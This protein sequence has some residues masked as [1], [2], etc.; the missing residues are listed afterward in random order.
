MYWRIFAALLLSAGIVFLPVQGSGDDPPP[1]SP[2]QPT[3]QLRTATIG[4]AGGPMQ[5]S[6][7]RQEGTLAQPTP[8]GTATGSGYGLYSGIWK[9]WAG[10]ATGVEEEVPVLADQ[11]YQNYPNPF[12]PT[13]T[14]RYAVASNSSVELTIYNVRGQKVRRLVSE[15]KSPGRY[16]VNWDG[17]S[18]Q[19]TRVA[20]GVYFYRIQIGTYTAVKKMVVLK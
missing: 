6:G 16:T 8:V 1:K 4:A 17:T 9:D 11:L 15:T 18:D 5:N 12:N 2:S 7:F 3:Y 20:S 14:I 10:P 13:T 19:G